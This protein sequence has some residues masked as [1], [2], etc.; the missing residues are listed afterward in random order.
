MVRDPLK[1]LGS[2]KGVTLSAGDHV[3]DKPRAFVDRDEECFVTFKSISIHPGIV[4]YTF[5]PSLGWQR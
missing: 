5:N 3:M 4:A 2:Q 1:D